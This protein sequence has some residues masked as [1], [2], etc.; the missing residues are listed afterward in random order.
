MTDY[1]S[2]TGH[3]PV[4]GK[5]TGSGYEAGASG[6]GESGS[7]GAT[8]QAKQVVQEKVDQAKEVAQQA[9]GT[10]KEQVGQQVDTHSTTVGEQ[11]GSVGEAMRKAGDHLRSQGSDMPAQLAERAAEQVEKLGS[12]L[13]NTD[14]NA[15]LG[16]VEDFARRQPLIVIAG[17]VALGVVAARMLKASSQRAYSGGTSGFFGGGS[18]SRQPSAGSENYAG[19]APSTYA[20]PIDTT[21]AGTAGGGWSGEAT[22]GSGQWGTHAEPG[23]ARA[24]GDQAETGTAGAGGWTGEGTSGAQVWGQ[25]GGDP[26][27]RQG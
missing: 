7:S 6:S 14:G 11:V 8:G 12:Y 24:F 21:T 26:N 15:I 27:P 2:S 22:T 3:D 20:E 25:H 1:S 19:A 4:T 17:G 23:T 5:G 16:D 9:A 18:V 10:A 13:R